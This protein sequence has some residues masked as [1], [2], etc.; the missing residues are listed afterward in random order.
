[1]ED[2]DKLKKIGE[3]YSSGR[4]LTS[5]IKQELAKVLIDLIGNIQD[6][7]SKLTDEHVAKFFSRDKRMFMGK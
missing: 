5:E 1:M 6:N 4:M 3:D 2:D 7:R